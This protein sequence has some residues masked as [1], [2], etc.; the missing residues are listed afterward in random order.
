MADEEIKTLAVAIAMEDGSFQSGVK[1]LKQQLGVID[2]EFK[3]SIA[4]VKDWGK[5]LDGLKANATALGDKINVQKQI[6]QQYTEQLQK[7]KDALAT[8]SQKMLDLKGKVESAKVAWEQSKATVGA[9]AEATKA[10]EAEYSKLNKQYES[11]ESLVRKN[12]TSVQGYSIQL[13]SAKGAL[14]NMDAELAKTNKA[15]DL[16]S[17][18]WTKLGNHLDDVRK[19]LKPVGEEFTKAGR[20]LSMSITAPIAALGTASATMATAFEDGMAK[21]S[22][23]ADEGAM[24]IEDLGDKVLKLSDDTGQAAT[25]IQEGLYDAISAGVK[26]ADSTDFMTTAV[27]AAKGG[28]TDTKTSVDGLTTTLN[29]YGLEASKATDIANQMMVAQNLGKTTFGEMA[30][31]IGNVV[32]TA[33]ALGVQTNEL[34]SSLASLTANGIKTSEAVTGLKAAYSNIV[35]PTSAAEKAAGQLGLQFNASHLQSVGWGK[36]LEEVKQKTGGNIETMAQLFGSTEAVNTVLTLTS[37]QGAKLFSDSMSQMASGTNFVDDAFN[38]VSNTSGQ[39][40]KKSFNELKNAGIQIGE[41][42]APVLEKISGVFKGLAETL[43]SMSPEQRQM[44]IVFAGI[45]AAI[46][47]VLVAVGSLVTAVSAIAGAFAAASGAI[48]AAGGI[49]AIITGPIGITVAAIAGLVAGGIALYKHFS[50]DAIPAVQLFGKETSDATKKAVGAYMDLDDKA[51]KSLMSL[52][53][54]GKTVTKE[55]ADAIT[56]N[57][58]DM[59]T[60]I[61]TGMDKHYGESFKTMQ[62]FF[63]ISSTLTTVEEATALAAMTKNN[64][65]KKKSVDDGEK[66]IKLILDTASTA[67]RALTTEEQTKINEIQATMKTNAVKALSDTELESKSILERMKAQAGNLTAEQAAEVAK[68]SIEQKDKAVKAANDQYD[69]TVKAIIKQRDET[70]SITTEQANK[71]ILEAGRQ[72]DE[73]VTKATEMNTKVVDQAKLQAK[74]HV[75]EVDWTTGEIKS[76]WR[77][78]KEDTATKMDEIGKNLGTKWEEIKTDTAKKVEDI[79]TG[80]I[81]AFK[82]LGTS[83]EETWN[84]IKES[85]RGSINSI[86]GTIN[87][88]IRHINNIRIN[89][90]MVNIP[91]VGT[92]GGYSIGMPQIPTI[93]MLAA[94]TNFVPADMLA[95]LHKGEAVVPAKYNQNNSSSRTIII[96]NHGTIVGSNGMKEFAK[97]VSREIAG[98][99]G[100]GSGGGW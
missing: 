53:F 40:L 18:N 4:G 80:A 70:G 2:S 24:S 49:I 10:L 67:K 11:A 76:K 28:F 81:N 32:P 73:S 75:K 72:K 34:F 29:S 48:A 39:N 88:F 8:N 95:F 56:K 92:F 61:K 26:T 7:S 20:T 30:S 65:D 77:I 14:S 82:G 83:V 43:K 100:L 23:V 85:M 45:A 6:V 58:D 74:D 35:K 16:Q 86:I 99:F 47:P 66:A 42:L 31:S 62:D 60:Q 13:N 9:N 3:S 33:A 17:S 12:N 41:S 90:P 94:G 19:K 5:G 78:M 93:P 68:N 64:E 46:G 57:F 89:V 59:G 1:N 44:V 52:N 37:D 84:G 54:S 27:K 69:Q 21:V 25:D 36:F 50:A 51:T 71:L 96:N 97:I 55:T 91:L 63:A 15:I 22:T 79:K 38:K 87:E 98:E